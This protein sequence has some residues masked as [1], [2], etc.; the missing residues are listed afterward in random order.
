M[1]VK[2]GTMPPAA[3]LMSLSTSA[4]QLVLFNKPDLSVEGLIVLADV[5]VRRDR[6]KAIKQFSF[7]CVR[8]RRCCDK[9][10]LNPLESHETVMYP[11]FEVVF[12][13]S[14]S[15]ELRPNSTYHNSLDGFGI[16]W[17]SQRP[18]YAEIM[19]W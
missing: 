18:Y 7:I 5:P 15:P 2:A 10:Q 16:V 4:A 9:T 8:C 13:N 14:N 17:T 1:T 3:F 6:I 19:K 11:V 12:D